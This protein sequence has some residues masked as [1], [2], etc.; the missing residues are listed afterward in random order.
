MNTLLL[1]PKKH[2]RY[3]PDERS[4]D[5]MLKTIKFFEDKG[6][7]KLKADDREGLWYADLLNFQRNEEIF[8]TLLTPTEYGRGESRWDTWRNCEFNEIL[9]FY[10]LAYWYTW[11]V[12]I[13]G[14]DPS[15]KARMMH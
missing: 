14:L 12:S 10:G 13:L 5:V 7:Q 1:N 4:K 3:Y 11:Q 15:G 2:N 8:A 9:A 6:K